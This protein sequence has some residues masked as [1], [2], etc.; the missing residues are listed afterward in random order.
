MSIRTRTWTDDDKNVAAE[1][2]TSYVNGLEQVMRRFEVEQEE[3]DDVLLDMNV[4]RCPGCGWYVDS[5]ALLP[6]GEDEPDGCCPNC[7]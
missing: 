4:E 6:H 3:V 7:R 5:H 2:A 1:L